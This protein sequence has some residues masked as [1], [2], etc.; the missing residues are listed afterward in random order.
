VTATKERP[1][2][3]RTQVDP[4][5]VERRQE[6]AA[7]TDRVR[8]RALVLTGVVLG[9]VAAMVSVL[10]TPLL[11]VDHV[12]VEG[13]ASP[14]V[15]AALRSSGVE[16]GARM[17]EVDL[18]E[19]RDALLEVPGVRSATV[20][21]EWPSTIRVR[22]SEEV[23]LA[24]V[25][26]GERQVVVSTTGR[27]LDDVGTDG[28][29]AVDVERLEVVD[30]GQ[31]GERAVPDEVLAAAQTVQRLIPA[32]RQ[33]VA[34]AQLSASGSLSLVLT[35]GAT[36]RFGS[37]EDLPEKLTAAEGVLGQV[38]PSCREVIDVQEPSRV[39]VSRRAGCQPA[40]VTDTTVP[41]EPGTP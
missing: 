35:D 1:R 8:R 2:V 20:E 17:V 26:Q 10:F 21:R 24:V 38:E 4:R 22:L 40:Q 23:P 7:S 6:V 30:G 33:Q 34:A 19:V 9:T 13:A 29:V 39:T 41:A 11:D 25:R 28:L 16:P 36:I 5:L 18:A 32:A 3:V 15:D 31:R 27:V 12:R 37:T 14:Q